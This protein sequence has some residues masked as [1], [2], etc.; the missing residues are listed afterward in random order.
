MTAETTTNYPSDSWQIRNM[1]SIGFVFL[2]LTKMVGAPSGQ[3]SKSKGR[4]FYASYFN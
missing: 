3:L 2:N 4:F 1:I